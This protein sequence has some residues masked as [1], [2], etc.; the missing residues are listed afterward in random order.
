MQGTIHHVYTGGAGTTAVRLQRT[1]PAAS[2]FLSES[3]AI[4]P[5]R[6]FQAFTAH[7]E[8]SHTN[9]CQGLIFPLSRGGPAPRVQQSPPTLTLPAVGV[10]RV[11][12]PPAAGPGATRG[13]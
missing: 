3:P 11:P 13:Y 10:P 6:L 1:A 7:T 8:V 2:G 9:T 12:L 4:D 5:P